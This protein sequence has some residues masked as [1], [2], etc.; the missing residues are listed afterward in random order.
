MR[1]GLVCLA[2]LVVAGC[3][4]DDGGSGGSGAAPPPAATPSPPPPPPP[5]SPPPPPV[6]PGTP[7]RGAVVA[8][9]V[10]PWAMTF[11]PDGR[12]LVTE[13]AGQMLLVSADG[14][15]RQ[16]VAGT[17][18]VDAA[19]Q[20][21][22]MDVVLAPDFLVSGRVYFTYSAT[23]SGGKG[24][25]LA[26]GRLSATGTPQ[27]TDVAELFRAS[28]FVGGDGHYSGRIAFSPDNQYLF[29]TSGDR[30]QGSPAQSSTSTL[31]KVLRLTL[32]GQP[33][34]GN[35][36][37]AQGFNPAIWSYGHRNL[38]GIAF[39][40]AGNLWEHE[41]G[42]QGGDELNLILPGRNYG[43]PIVSD[44]SNYDGSLIPDHVTRPDLE[45]PKL[46]W[47]PVIAPAGLIIY[48]GNLFPQWR[49]DAFMGGLASQALIRVD[50][51]GTTARKAEQWNM[52]ARIREVEQGPDGV[53]WI[54]ED[55][56]SSAGR[57]I[58]LTP[59]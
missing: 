49:G 12:M 50:L 22:L 54:L 52:G 14:G 44:G 55:G 35:P 8:D 46:S 58:K 11:L 31:G 26:R 47:N 9:L 42:P 29:L 34:P 37:A 24:M 1:S 4:G 6:I 36:L 30:Q 57:L 28:P 7:F 56:G 18:A 45:A 13:K 43:W 20:G 16:T 10:S 5:P 40:A 19:G 25:V 53:I 39:D 32:N 38:L 17:P 59:A 51:D 27:L 33:A 21:G 2:A 23:G 41:M 3:G 15:S 48:S